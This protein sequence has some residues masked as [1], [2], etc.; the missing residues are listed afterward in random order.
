MLL[1]VWIRIDPSGGFFHATEAN[2]HPLRNCRVLC[3]LNSPLPNTKFSENPVCGQVI[4]FQHNGS[5]YIIEFERSHEMIQ[6]PGSQSHMTRHADRGGRLHKRAATARALY[7][8]LTTQLTMIDAPFPPQPSIS[9]AH[10][11]RR[12]SPAVPSD[13]PV[14]DHKRSVALSLL[15]RIT[16]TRKGNSVQLT[17]TRHGSPP[18]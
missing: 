4:E 2:E 10:F 5:V 14:V 7:A 18:A 15:A 1:V 13:T 17:G 16:A 8:Q 12:G 3:R 9:V 11:P 6:R